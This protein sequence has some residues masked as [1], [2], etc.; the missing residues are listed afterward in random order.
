ML[1]RLLDDK[2]VD[3]N[4][5]IKEDMR[6]DR[7][8]RTDPWTVYWQPLL[9]RLI[10]ARNFECAQV[11]LD[12]GARVD[13]CEWEA[14]STYV[15]S[16]EDNDDPAYAFELWDEYNSFPGKTSLHTLVL[17]LKPDSLGTRRPPPARG[18]SLLKRMAALAKERGCLEWTATV[19]EA[20]LLPSRLYAR[21]QQC[22]L[23][24]FL[25]ACSSL[26]PVLVDAFI[27]AGAC[28]K[29]GVLKKESPVSLSTLCLRRYPDSPTEEMGQ[30][31]VEVLRR[32]AHNG[33]DLDPQVEGMSQQV[34]A[35]PLFVALCKGS[36][37]LV[38]FLVK[39]GG[40]T[41]T[42]SY[43][44]FS[45]VLM[46]I[47]HRR[48]SLA[49]VLLDEH[50]LDPNREDREVEEFGLGLDFVFGDAPRGSAVNRSRNPPQSPPRDEAGEQETTRVV[51]TLIEVGA[52][53]DLLSA[54]LK[55]RGRRILPAGFPLATDGDQ[56][57]S[58]QGKD[59]PGP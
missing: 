55:L 48:W 4:M 37:K 3:P 11:L 51:Q 53:T 52:R 43:R 22:E 41:I 30:S 20:A 59:E 28:V 33:V 2:L 12:R 29:G 1:C 49:A 45:P 47:Q 14:E 24:P 6:D 27:E 38:D 15:N 35:L 19:P 10:D 58:E 23:S 26:Q 54:A 8:L 44:G 18:L 7:Q 13:V 42:D 46:C 40:L 56:E 5:W 36:E 25:L 9:S 16:P 57:E 34:A 39:E 17:A 32:L 21:T 31:C 50:N